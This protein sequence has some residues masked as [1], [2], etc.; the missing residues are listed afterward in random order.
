MDST[1]LEILGRSLT[2][3]ALVALLV[4]AGLPLSRRLGL[5]DLPGGRK[6][7][8]EPTSYIGG[9][10][11]LFAIAVSFLVFDGESN[12]TATTFLGCAAMLAV[13]GFLDDWAGLGPRVRLLAQMTAALVMILVAGVQVH[14]LS[15]VFAIPE[16]HL[17]WLAI[18]LTV[19]IV[20]G[21]INALN[22]IDGSDGLAGGQVVVALVLFSAFAFYAGNLEMVARLAT[23]AAAVAGFLVWNL[24]FPWQPR[25]RI[26]LGNAGSM[27]LGFVVAW[28]AVR[29]SQEPAHPVSPVLGP[30][31]LA[32]P[33]IDCVT[34]MFRRISEG[35]SPFQADR[36]HLHH[37]LLDAG[38]TPVGIAWGLMAV[39]LALGLGAGIAVQQDIYRP[40]LVAVFVILL[41][42]YYQATRDR[43]QAVARL[44]TLRDM[45]HG[46]GGGAHAH[47]RA[48]TG[49]DRGR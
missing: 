47:A 31:A 20:V 32:I 41:L 37:L 9:L 7:H 38:F 4:P 35:R 8:E 5:Y 48:A 21:V 14:N 13:V 29:L 17:G 36:N 15:D 33:L 44:R 16:L 22:M 6:Q 49:P 39:S 42:A 12:L 11:I 43:A 30:W 23:V 34:L 3:F 1:A 10:F 27:V 28:A 2:A 45:L 46:Q 18:P 40:V 24:R 19:F 25:A 26:F